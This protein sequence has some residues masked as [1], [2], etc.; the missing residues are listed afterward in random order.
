MGQG[1]GQL[2]SVARAL[3]GTACQAIVLVLLLLV[4]VAG[5]SRGLIGR[6][7]GGRDCRDGDGG[8]C[9]ISG[10]RLLFVGVGDC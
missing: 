4:S 9:Q 7:G 1:T 10:F 2:R 8:I 3:I 5:R 6:L